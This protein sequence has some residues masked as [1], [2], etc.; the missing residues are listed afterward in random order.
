MPRIAEGILKDRRSK[1][2]S[3]RFAHDII[4]TLWDP[5]DEHESQIGFTPLINLMFNL[6]EL[7]IGDVFQCSE[8]DEITWRIAV[9]AY[10]VIKRDFE[11]LK[12]HLVVNTLL[13]DISA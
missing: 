1:L 2:G 12:D 6:D 7:E 10:D 13:L 4:F 11:I 3:S 8:V 9:K 5:V